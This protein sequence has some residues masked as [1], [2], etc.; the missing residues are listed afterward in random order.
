MKEIEEKDLLEFRQIDQTNFKQVLELKRPESEDFVA[1]VVYSLAEAW[2]YRDEQIINPFAVY[3][4]EKLIAFVMTSEEPHGGV[5]DIWR[6][7]IPEQY[8]GKGYGT[9]ILQRMIHE[10]EQK[11][12]DSIQLSYV[13]GNAMAEHV[14]RK[15]GFQATGVVDDG[16][17]VMRLKCK[18]H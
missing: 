5:L 15:V 11:S 17:I 7:L 3:V 10:A 16:E 1:P 4:G 6:I 14:Y 8:T 9:L 13:P 18:E 12:Y 2:L